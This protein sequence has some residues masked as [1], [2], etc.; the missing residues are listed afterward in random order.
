M[1]NF[2]TRCG[3]SV[4]REWNVCPYCGCIIHHM[5][6]AQKLSVEA[7]QPINQLSIPKREGAEETRLSKSQ[8]VAIIFAAIILIAAIIIPFVGLSI[9]NF[10]IL[11]REVQFYVNNGWTFTSYT[12][13]TPR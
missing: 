9:F 1:A 6:N 10:T 12:I 11:Q 8:K 5:A 13:S 7:H 3:Q 4:Q 2:C